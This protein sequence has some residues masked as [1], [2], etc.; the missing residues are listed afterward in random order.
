MRGLIFAL[1]LAAIYAGSCGGNCISDDCPKCYCGESINKV[2]VEK[3]CKMAEWDQRCCN[4]IVENSSGG[5]AN[6]V[7][8]T[9]KYTEVG[10]FLIDKMFWGYCNQGKA[11]CSFQSNLMCAMR[12]YIWGKRWHAWNAAKK[13]NCY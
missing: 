3:V 1:L 8:A 4:C 7:N 13:C 5:N 9:A 6:A 12:I 10:L 2:D 11:P